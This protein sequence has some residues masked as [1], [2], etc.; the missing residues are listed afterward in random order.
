MK[1]CNK[2]TNPSKKDLKSK[3]KIKPSK[4]DDESLSDD[5]LDVGWDSDEDQ[6]ITGTT[7]MSKED[8]YRE[9]EDDDFEGGILLSDVLA[10]NLSK[11]K[12]STKNKAKAKADKE[13]HKRDQPETGN[14]KK[15]AFLQMDDSVVEESSRKP[16][17][18]NKGRAVVEVESEEEDE[19][20]MDESGDSEEDEENGDDYD[21]SEGMEIIDGSDYED[22]DMDEAEIS[23][24]EGEEDEEDASGS[25]EDDD[26][27]DDEEIDEDENDEDGEDDEAH[28]R[29]IT[30]I[31]SKFSNNNKGSEDAISQSKFK[32]QLLPESSTMTFDENLSLNAL[33]GE[34][35]DS[36]GLEAVKSAL[37]DLDKKK[38]A[39]KYVEKVIANRLERKEVYQSTKG[40]MDKWHDTVISNRHAPVLDLA[41]D[42]RQS[43]RAKDLVTK[44][45]PMT[46]MEKEIQMVLVQSGATESAMEQ[47]EV[48][49]L[50]ARN[51]SLEEIKQRQADLAKVNA[52]M[53]YEQMKRH[54][55]NKIKSKAYRTIRRKQ[56]RREQGLADGE[57]MP[58]DEVD[59]D[60]TAAL[61]EKNA[62][63]R[64]KERMDLKHKNTSKWAKM[65]LSYGHTDKSLRDAYH[66]SVRLGQELTKKMKERVGDKEEDENDNS[67]EVMD[68]A[69]SMSVAAKSE[70][71]KMF[72]DE[73]N[74]GDMLV[75]GKYKKLF[76]M[77][78]MKKASEQQ[79]MR[80]RE[81]AQQVLKE[82]EALEGHADSD[83]VEG[84]VNMNQ[85]KG[86]SAEERK[87]AKQ[88]ISLLFN[89]NEGSGFQL[90]LTK[91]SVL[92]SS[93][94]TPVPESTKIQQPTVTDSKKVKFKKENT[95]SK[96]E[97]AVKVEEVVANPWLE[98][99]IASGNSAGK[100]RGTDQLGVKP[101]SSAGEAPQVLV[102]VPDSYKSSSMREKSLKKE[103]MPLK[104]AV[105]KKV[106]SG[107]TQ[108]ELVQMAFAGPD[109]EADFLA[110]KQQEIDRELGIDDKK[111]KILKDGESNLL[112]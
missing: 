86:M 34:L 103:E 84:V 92:S 104:E 106:L 73:N 48:E 95:V 94:L 85:R 66:E 16:I 1:K 52:L 15:T 76:E 62:F 60:E 36:Q 78:F 77:D 25:E 8:R 3:G 100:K 81:E 32:N 47:K 51:I 56:K 46:D 44:F 31:M 40:E 30:S 91:P 89:Q 107:K 82:I 10:Q 70:F 112:L 24:D 68:S 93:S 87:V 98:V 33:L 69:Q 4:D 42:K 75:D 12:S 45:K 17:K 72:D 105:E 9:E 41:N 101:K 108:E 38:K 79:R 19:S 11:S 96:E 39:P 67:F 74:E 111:M 26:E 53:F 18:G 83:A 90:N 50:Q 58:E 13:E 88:S 6:F 110:H 59:H 65:A 20:D 54:R 27:Q 49:M 37:D 102:S 43:T 64:V 29:L 99:T 97:S 7:K 28:S 22:E 57:E 109:F 55:I 21:D 2:A 71:K 14:K 35:Q 5:G 23:G 61:D 63:D 80:A